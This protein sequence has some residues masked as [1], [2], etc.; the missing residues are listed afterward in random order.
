[1]ARH[2]LLRLQAPLLAFGGE[3]IDNY[4]VI[5]DFPA[6]S[7]LTGMLANA[8]GWRREDAL[9]HS[10]LQS[11]LVFGA[12]LDRISGRLTDFQTAQL[13]KDD[14]GWT[15]WGTPE[16]RRGGAGTY[17]APHLRYRDFLCDSAVLVALRLQASNE[18]PTVD[19]LAQALDHPARPLFIGRKPC[20][21]SAR[22]FAGW[23]DADTILQALQAASP[24]IKMTRERLRVQWPEGE[25]VLPGD[26]LLEVCD[27]RD[28][29]SG[30]HGGWRAIRE[31]T[32]TLEVNG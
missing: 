21:P 26:R 11:R 1:M 30:V 15:T 31:G 32:I 24:L 5:R 2:L 27:E 20:L 14:K 8:L 18:A 13:S 12:R 7:M 17:N 28:W 22:V 3:A 9:E 6:G 25:G 10:R 19:D 23:V 16:E 4:G 29:R